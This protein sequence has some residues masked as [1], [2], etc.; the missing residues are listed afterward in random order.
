MDGAWFYHLK[1]GPQRFPKGC[2]APARN[3]WV[4]DPQKLPRRNALAPPKKRR[5]AA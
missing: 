3:G 2:V 4:D 1:Y 5:R